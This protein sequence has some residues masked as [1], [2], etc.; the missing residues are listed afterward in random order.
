[1]K[2]IVSTILFVIMVGIASAQVDTKFTTSNFPGRANE[3][4]A[5]KSSIKSGDELFYAGDFV[6]ALKYYM[7]A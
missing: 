7:S 4:N 1:M 3:V 5:A 2:T 6:G